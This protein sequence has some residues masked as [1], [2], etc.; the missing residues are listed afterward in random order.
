MA[1]VTV[2]VLAEHGNVSILQLPQRRFPVAAIQGDSLS[3]LARLTQSV[4]AH[5]SRANDADLRD[6]VEELSERLNEILHAYEAALDAHGIPL[7]Y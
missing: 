2:R 7:P 6:E 5:A 4:V 3:A 1:T